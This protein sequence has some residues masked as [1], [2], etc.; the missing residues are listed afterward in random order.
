LFATADT[1]NRT[2]RLNPSPLA[3]GCIRPADPITDE[4]CSGSR[5][6]PLDRHDGQEDP[7]HDTRLSP[8]P[9]TVIGA[10]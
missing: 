5:A 4:R 9:I 10:L 1:A 6:P 3:D 7:Q 2:T 8:A